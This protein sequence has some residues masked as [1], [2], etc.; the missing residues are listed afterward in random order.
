MLRKSLPHIHAVVAKF[1]SKTDELLFNFKVQTRG[2]VRK[3]PNVVEWITALKHLKQQGANVQE[4]IRKYN[5]GVPRAAQI[6]GGKAKTV[7]NLM[8]GLPEKCLDL[9][10]QHCQKNS[11][12]CS[13]F[14]DDCLA[15]KKIAPGYTHR[16][17][18]LGD[19]WRA[20]GKVSEESLELMVKHV[21]TVFETSPSEVRRKL[22]QQDIDT[23]SE[24]SAFVYNV[25]MEA[26]KECPIE[27]SLLLEKWFE[28]WVCGEFGCTMEVTSQ[29]Q[30]K[31]PELT[32]RGVK[33][34]AEV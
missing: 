21:I 28:P 31:D 27:D 11:W 2:V 13:A 14:S 4:V 18:G 9:I 30:R 17:P 8:E 24:E 7:K 6:A 23:K 29:L 3:L 33:Q 1:P 34:L 10:L 25:A 20:R 16:N 5:S 26:K 19:A 15:S 32:P 12:E 22:S